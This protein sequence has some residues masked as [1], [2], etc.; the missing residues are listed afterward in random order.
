MI[1]TVTAAVTRSSACLPA[2]LH[3]FDYMR[4]RNKRWG[5]NLP[6][7][8]KVTRGRAGKQPPIPSNSAASDQGGR[9]TER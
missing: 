4:A 5:M 2:Q 3:N 1:T 8:V 7:V 9:R 6:V